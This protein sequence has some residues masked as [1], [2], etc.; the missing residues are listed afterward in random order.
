[1]QKYLIKHKCRE[2]LT[3]HT[4]NALKMLPAEKI[5]TALDLGCGTGVCS[6]TGLEMTDAKLIS[7]DIDREALDFFYQIVTQKELGSRVSL[8]DKSIFEINLEKNTFDLII[9]EGIFHL[10]GFEKSVKYFTGFLK[11][12][13]YMLI[14]DEIK[15]MEIK[16]KIFRENGLEL[17]SLRNIGINE[18]KKYIN[19]LKSEIDFLEKSKI[20]NVDTTL[21]KSEI[22]WF[23]KD[24]SSFQ[25]VY[26]V[27]KKS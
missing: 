21:E 12:D 11:K 10:T 18:W 15:D 13:G 20:N 7:A 3:E 9:A 25:S 26:Y 19:C 2:I 5:E 17:I 27:L 4:R 23:Q 22:N 14:H 16:M 8:I 24:P 6:L 1:M